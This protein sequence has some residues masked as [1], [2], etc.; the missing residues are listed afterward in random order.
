MRSSPRSC[1]RCVSFGGAFDGR[2]QI[3]NNPGQVPSLGLNVLGITSFNSNVLNEVQH[4]SN[5]FGVVSLQKHI[6][7]IDLQISAFVR[8]SVLSFS[9]TS[10]GLPVDATGAQTSIVPVN[11]SRT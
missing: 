3:P 7:D 6:D 1:Y 5:Q 4:E 8:N 11:I 10:S 9:P 2:F